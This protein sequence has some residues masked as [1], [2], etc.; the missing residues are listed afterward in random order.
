MSLKS[1]KCFRGL[2]A[3]LA[4]FFLLTVTGQALHWHDHGGAQQIESSCHF[5]KTGTSQDQAAPA[6]RAAPLPPESRGMDLPKLAHAFSKRI[7]DGLPSPRGPP[8]L[9]YS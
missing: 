5:C 4:L 2:G 6:N 1:G 3:A 7:L 9:R 8:S